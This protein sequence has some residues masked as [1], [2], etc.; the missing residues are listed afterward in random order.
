MFIAYPAY[1]NV[2]AIRSNIIRS[3]LRWVFTHLYRTTIGW[4]W[5]TRCRP[6]IS[7]FTSNML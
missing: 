5:S 6:H 2:V 1:A 4:G 7:Q 3:A